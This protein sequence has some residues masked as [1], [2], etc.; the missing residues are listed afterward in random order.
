VLASPVRLLVA[1]VL[2]GAGVFAAAAHASPAQDAVAGRPTCLGR[3][4]SSAGAV[5][6]PILMYHRVSVATA[7]TP[8]VT[9]RLTVS[10]T[11]FA[12]HLRWLHDNGYRTI[13][14]RELLTALRCGRGLGRR[15][16]MITF[17]DGYR[18]AFSRAS[19]LLLRFGMRAT[20][21]VITGRISKGD[22]D[23][24]TWP[25][26]RALEARGVEIGSHTV[27]HVDLTALST[28]RVIR[29]LVDARLQL[30]R[31]LSHPVR[32][33]AYPF[34]AWNPRVEQLARDAG[35][36]LAV[37]T[38]PGAV[39]RSSRPLALRRIRVSDTTSVPALAATL[40]SQ[41]VA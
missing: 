13:T 16:V 36:A 19:P 39:Q 2:G 14:Q 7:A 11:L 3:P 6:V 1:V 37:T 12:R 9:R 26:L 21:Y 38:D 18:D 33:L 28:R 4:Q 25:L 40:A 31:R 32:W 8:A 20:A 35:Y 17:D 23:S 22:A 34:G 24:L 30:E 27:S 5:V 29:E 15:P 41:D 10:P